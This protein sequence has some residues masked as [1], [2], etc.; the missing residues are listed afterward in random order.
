MVLKTDTYHVEKIISS[1]GSWMSF[2]SIH[3]HYGS[4]PERT[5]ISLTFL[6][7][8]ETGKKNTKKYINACG[9]GHARFS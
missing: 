5:I 1:P 7:P 3:Y 4:G 8:E 9:M 2:P 6:S